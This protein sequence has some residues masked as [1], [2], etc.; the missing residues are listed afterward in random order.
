MRGLLFMLPRAIMNYNN[1]I[2]ARGNNHPSGNIALFG[3]T[4]QG[5]Y[6]WDYGMLRAI[7]HIVDRG[8][9]RNLLRVGRLSNEKMR[10]IPEFGHRR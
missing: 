6:R 3:I 1:G 5:N 4:A 2:A 9:K 7:R 8:R 10:K